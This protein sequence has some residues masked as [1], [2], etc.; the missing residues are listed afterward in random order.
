MADCEEIISTSY[1]RI[2]NHVSR[3]LGLLDT[4]YGTLNGNAVVACVMIVAD[5]GGIIYF[6]VGRES[7]NL[8]AT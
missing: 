2:L 8:S 6:K 5:E 7:M 4:L 3:L 1:K